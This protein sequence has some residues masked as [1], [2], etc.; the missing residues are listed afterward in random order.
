LMLETFLLCFL[1]S[2]SSAFMVSD[3]GS[4]RSDTI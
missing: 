4:L 1:I 2:S 3:S